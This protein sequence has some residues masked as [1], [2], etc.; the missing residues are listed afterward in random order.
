M[1]NRCEQAAICPHFERNDARCAA[2]FNLD[3]IR[4]VFEQCLGDYTACP[5][6]YQ[7]A[8]PTDLPRA[9]GA[10]AVAG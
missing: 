10:L 8:M 4:D 2:R 5:V 7:L 3:R 6:Y 1:L 9:S